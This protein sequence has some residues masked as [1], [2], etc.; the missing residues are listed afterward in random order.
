MYRRGETEHPNLS[1]F[2][3]EP[4]GYEEEEYEDEREC[5]GAQKDF[6]PPKL[7]RES[8]GNFPKS[9]QDTEDNEHTVM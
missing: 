8:Q 2:M 3:E 6:K 7:D 5:L 4:Q 1:S 9:C